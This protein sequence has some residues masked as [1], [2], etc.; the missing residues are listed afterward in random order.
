[1][2]SE[3]PEVGVVFWFLHGSFN[4]REFRSSA[5]F[6][7]SLSKGYI[8]TSPSNTT[9]FNLFL[10]LHVSIEVDHHQTFS[11]NPQ[12]GDKILLFAKSLKYFRIYIIIKL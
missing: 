3:L 12:K 4:D 7:R 9:L 5:F 10:T 8:N 2:V 11:T 6:I 1:V